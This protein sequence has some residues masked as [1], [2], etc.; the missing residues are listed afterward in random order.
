MQFTRVFYSY[1]QICSVTSV[2]L[3]MLLYVGEN[4]WKIQKLEI[5]HL[6]DRRSGYIDKGETF[7]PSRSMEKKGQAKKF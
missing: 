3:K 2:T 5:F 6:I 7:A 1:F 4:H